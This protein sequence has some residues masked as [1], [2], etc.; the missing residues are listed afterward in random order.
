MYTPTATQTPAVTP[1]SYYFLLQWGTFSA[2]AGEMWWP[3]G[4]AADKD[5]NIY[6]VDTGNNRIQKFTRDGTFLAQWGTLGGGDG[7]FYNPYGIA[8]DGSGYVYVT[9]NSNHRVQK[10]T[11]SGAFVTISGEV[12]VVVM[13]SFGILKVL[14]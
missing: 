8:V 6:V 14:R 4:V 10:F 9:D 5:G 12:L 11:S 1:P 7:Q 13:G 3:Q 2:V